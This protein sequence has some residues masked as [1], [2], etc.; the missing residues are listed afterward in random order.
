MAFIVDNLDDS[1]DNDLSCDDIDEY[2]GNTKKNQGDNLDEYTNNKLLSD[3]ESVESKEI[4]VGID[5]GTTNSCISIWRNN[6]LEVIPDN[7]GNKTIPSIVA[8]TNKTKYVG[9]EAKNQIILNPENT[10]YEVKRLIGRKFNEPSIENDLPFFTFKIS[11]GE[12]MS[13]VINPTLEGR[14]H[15]YT[16]E[17]ISSLIL[18]ELKL[19]AEDYLKISIEK[20]VITVPAYF[21]D[22][23]RQ[24]TKDASTIAGLECVRIINEPTAAG[25]AYGLEKLTKNKDADMNILVYDCG[26]GTLD[27]SVLNISDG[28]FEVLGSTGNTHMGGID[29][30]NR[31]VNYC[32]NYFKKK[33]TINKLKN[34][35]LISLQKLRKSCENAKKILSTKL[36]TYIAV[37]DFYEDKNLFI[38]ITRD[39]YT[40][41]CKDLF[42]L[43]L[44]PVED[45]LN[46]CELERE[47]IDEIILVGGATKM[48]QI[49]EN[50]KLFFRGKI[51]NATINPDEVVAAGAAIQGYIIANE[52]DPFSE[53]VV[54]LDVIPLSLGIETIGGIMTNLIPRNSV[55]PIK[56]KKKFTTI[57]DNETSVII[58]IFEGER[59]MTKDNFFVGEFELCGL[60]ETV[61]G[62]PEIDVCF[63]VDTNGIISVTATDI[64]NDNNKNSITITGNKGRL[65]PDKINELVNDAKKMELIDKLERDK[66][67]LFYEIDDLC[68]NI[69]VNLSNSEFQLKVKDKNIITNDIDKI[70]GWLEQ[71]NFLDRSKREYASI[72]KK[73]KKKYGTLMLRISNDQNNVKA[74][75]MLEGDNKNCGTT[76]FGK[77]EDLEEYEKTIF[78]EIDNDEY[79]F[80]TNDKIKEELK[81]LREQL[82]ELC[83]SIYEIVN[84][85]EFMAKNNHKCDLKDY[86]NDIL[87]WLHVKEKI[88][89]SEF[90][91]KIDEINI[92]CNNIV[93]KYCEEELFNRNAIIKNIKTD[94]DELEQLCYAIKSSILSNL[95]SLE[96]QKIKELDD[97]IDTTLKWIIKIDIKKRKCELDNSKFILDNK[98]YREKIDKI[99]DFCTM[100]YH[101]MNGINTFEKKQDIIDENIIFLSNEHTNQGTTIQSIKVKNN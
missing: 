74:G 55:I 99:N 4:I 64:K 15:E 48:H 10:F 72:L 8:F 46:L 81:Q 53:S 6:N 13:V 62:I 18:L 16:A 36:K 95:F 30:D 5:L 56:R 49:R 59:K 19:M 70:Y 76:V 90:K 38:S 25:L 40:A 12:N 39:Q 97:L 33:F 89:K 77:D 75:E 69:K 17:E 98:C 27:C 31:I 11:E 67:Q 54:L 84:S 94:R 21:N 20:A 65:T 63:M 88:T 29:F 7:Y 3:K 80:V 35:S 42:I 79:N 86:I 43:C 82:E 71:K 22:S 60:D 1:Y 93:E 32:K 28:I 100:L 23:Q 92:G 47:D 66:K 68:S 26:G 14:K 41:I 34:L 50:L 83:Y 96:E 101:D 61:R 2:F 87:L 57:S 73:I 91:Q 44:K 24:A 52:S 51:P 58:K 85:E 9:K 37:K 78:E 45:V